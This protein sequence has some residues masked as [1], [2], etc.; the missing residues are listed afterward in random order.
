MN[1][2]FFL[3]KI[4]DFNKTKLFFFSLIFFFDISYATTTLAQMPGEECVPCEQHKEYTCEGNCPGLL[5]DIWWE[6]CCTFRTWV[7]ESSMGDPWQLCDAGGGTHSCQNVCLLKPENQP[8]NPRWYDDQ[9]KNN[10]AAADKGNKNNTLPIVLDWTL[11]SWKDGG[12]LNPDGSKKFG[13]VSNYGA[14]SFYIEIDNPNDELFEPEKVSGA[15][16]DAEKKVLGKCLHGD[17]FNSVTDGNPCLFRS[18]KKDITYRVKACCTSDCTNCGPFVKWSF[19]TGDFPEPKSP[20]DPDWNGPKSTTGLSFKGLQVEW[21]KTWMTKVTPNQW[22]K[23]YRLNVTSDET[24]TQKCHP[25]LIKNN[26]CIDEDILLDTSINEVTTK[27][28]IK[29]RNDLALFTRDQT[30][31]WKMKTCFDESSSQCS[32]YGQSWSLTPKTEPIG[33]SAATTPQDDPQG[34]QPVGLP[35]SLAWTAPDGSNSFIFETSFDISAQKTAWL[36]VP[37]SDTAENVKAKFDAPNLKAD[38]EYKWRVKACS[39]FNST[40]CDDW[41]PWFTF[42]TTG[43]PPKEDSLKQTTQ[44]PVIFNWEAVPGAKSYVFTLY[45]TGQEIKSVIIDG[46]SDLTK[47]T[48]TVGYPDIDQSQAYSWKIKTCAH[49]NGT[50]CGEATADMPIR[51]AQ[52]M[53][54]ENQQPANNSTIYA[55]SLTHTVS[56]SAV[57]GAVAYL[58]TVALIEP[59]ANNTECIQDVIEKTVRTTTDE[60]KIDCL[61]AYELTVT[62]CL[63]ENCVSVGPNNVTKFVLAEQETANKQP[64]IVCGADYDD[65][66]TPWLERESCQPKHVFL[67]GKVALDFALFK[68]A[69]W[70]LPILV[71]VTALIFYSS[72]K[73]PEIWAKIKTSWKA[74]GIGYAILILAWVIVGLILQAIGFP[75]MWWKII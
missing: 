27:Y 58:Y 64:L 66:S 44:I 16:Y 57:P 60:I 26:Q 32:D 3:K 54:V 43:R 62:P 11:N 73:T 74:I 69:I 17:Y 6:P 25:L 18:G 51:T 5:L 36:T 67:M 72:L 29:G 34:N 7:K 13:A 53:P 19:S 12:G 15:T 63:D 9:T 65:P 45:K 21:C 2:S 46:E 35:L 33:N 22:A 28:P 52:L 75:G 48:L 31:F 41:S 1:I 59:A 24:G 47:P 39:K 68:F 61:G 50:V 55:S 30:Y 20:M 49:A 56:W 4:F 38:T 42:R 8:E 23:S 71:L 10:D 40:N 37:N 14:N 70:L